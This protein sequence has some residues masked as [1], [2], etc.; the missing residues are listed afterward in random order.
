MSETF[1]DNTLTMLEAAIVNWDKLCVFNPKLAEKYLERVQGVSEK[2]QRDTY[3]RTKIGRALRR[4]A[5]IDLLENA[6]EGEI[7]TTTYKTNDKN[8]DIK[9]VVAL[10]SGGFA[11][12]RWIE[13]QGSKLTFVEEENSWVK[14]SIECDEKTKHMLMGLVD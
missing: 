14:Y 12:T 4:D 2:F 6:K 1:D 5:F 9:Y 7:L 8:I 13:I 10:K 11:P 3:F